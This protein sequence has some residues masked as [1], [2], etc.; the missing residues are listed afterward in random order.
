L[1]VLFAVEGSSQAVLL[2]E[3]QYT[4]AAL[5]ALEVALFRLLESL[6]VRPDFLIG[7][8]IGELAAAHVAGVFSLRDAC[9]LVAARGRL[10]GA[11]PA[12]GAMVSLQ[13]SEQEALRT[14][15]G[16][17]GRA[18]LAAVNGPVAVVVSGEEDAVLDI[19]G[20]YQEQGRKTRRLR[21]SH[22]FHSQRMDPMLVE[23]AAVARGLSYAPPV[24]PVVSNVTGEPLADAE[25][26]SAEY[27]VRHVREPV[28][29]A[30]GVR[31]LG[32]QGVGSMLEL[33]PDG[34][35]SALV[36]EC[37]AAAELGARDAA[38]GGLG[39]EGADGG[40]GVEGA[41]G[42]GEAGGPVPAV[43]LLRRGRAELGALIGALAEAWTRGVKVD[44]GAL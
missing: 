11:L 41:D 42:G 15:S 43:A 24:L 40:V 39:V 29:F 25:I 33:G 44:W 9:A 20:L 1:E 5:F 7:H 17:E 10:M 2:D 31:W 14:L 16:F 32:S 3:T 30:A 28:R 38:R 4:Q 26:C 19:A 6:G 18:C 34:V 8:S 27:W 12:G 23:F 35:L 22:A 36:Q 21:V 37:L 13:A